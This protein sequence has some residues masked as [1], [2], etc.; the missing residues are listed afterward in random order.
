MDRGV[1][2]IGVQLA[3]RDRE[4]VAALDGLKTR[5]GAY[6][7]R[8]KRLAQAR[9]RHLQPV[10]R[11]G[12]G[13]SPERVDQRVSRHRAVGVQQQEGEQRKLSRTP[14]GEALLA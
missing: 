1:K 11:V 6:V 4:Q 8:L 3:R 13:G 7:D 2:R 5:P 14:Q 9:D 12:P 10:V